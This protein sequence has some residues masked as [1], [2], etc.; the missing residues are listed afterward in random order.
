VRGRYSPRSAVD[1]ARARRK[2]SAGSRQIPPARSLPWGR[3]PVNADG[4]GRI[5]RTR[6]MRLSMPNDVFPLRNSPLRISA[7]HLTTA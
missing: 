7:P 6:R 3:K 1:R 5:G 4:G 2:K